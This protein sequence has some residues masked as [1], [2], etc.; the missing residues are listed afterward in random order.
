[1]DIH[2]ADELA[3]IVEDD[4]FIRKA[5][6]AASTPALLATLIHLTG[7]PAL[8]NERFRPTPTMGTAFGTLPAEAHAELIDRAVAELGRLR[9]GPREPLRKPSADQIQRVIAFVLGQDV[10]GEY[11]PF[12]MDELGIEPLPTPKMSPPPGFHALIVGAGMSGLLAAIK[13]DQAGIAWTIVE[14]NPDVGGTWFENRY[15]GVRVDSPNHNYAY[16]FAPN[17]DW[18]HYFSQGAEILAYFRSI[19]DRFGLRERIRFG[20]ELVEARFDEDAGLWRAALAGP[21]GRE[22]VE[23]NILISAVG[24]LNRPRLPDIPGIADFAGPM[25]HSAQWDPSVD[26]AGKRV[27]M[28]GT[29]ASAMQIVPELA[30]IAEHV[31][32]FQR[33]APWITP[34]SVYR[35]PVEEGKSWLLGHVP[36]YARWYRFLLFYATADQVHPATQVD[37]DW[38]DHDRS[39]SAMSGM[40]RDGLEAMFRQQ[41]EG[42]PDL[43]EKVIPVFP[44]FGSRMLVDDGTWLATLRRD[45]VTL[46]TDGI[47]HV[48]ADG[49]VDG[50]GIMHEVDVLA[51]ATGFHANRFLWPMEIYGREGRSLAALWGDEPRAH[52]G[53]TV[54]GFPNLFILY[55]PG[56]N[57]A[58]GGSI[59]FTVECQVRMMLDALARMVEG[60]GTT[61]ECDAASYDAHVAE[62]SAMLATSVW[63]H[64]EARNWYRNR[65]GVVVNTMPFRLI[66]YWTWT[67]S[68]APY[69][70][71]VRAPAEVAAAD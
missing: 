22:T 35:K 59:I 3:P 6:E 15:P 37:P 61:I 44:P 34:Q 1:M 53:V 66:D 48:E 36:H 2:A 57:L 31:T 8:L 71:I 54:P 43:Y 55:G 42:R 46:V 11:T 4:A 50:K 49:V 23:A 21:D 40:V 70:Y 17:H 33:H 24:Q 16:S 14:K 12:A 29:G 18:S 13:L 20:T 19:A 67:K 25:M 10:P 28:I 52:L 56:T 7:D 62:L 69:D 41:T 38:P 65:R 51:L 60:G 45:N 64:P 68:V 58:F 26:F 47:D 9:D 27:A 30:R 32:V 63:A 5:L 39:I